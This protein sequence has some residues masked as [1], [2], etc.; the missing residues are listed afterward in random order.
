M[1]G[2][3]IHII[4]L[5]AF[6]PKGFAQQAPR[7]QI[8]LEDDWFSIAD[9]S[10]N[11]IYDKASVQPGKEAAGWQVVSIPH[12]WDTYHGVRRM[13]H[14]NRHGYAWY[15]HDFRVPKTAKPSRFF[16]FF[17][18]VGSYAAVFL[19]GRKVGEHA[20]GRTSFTLDI[21]DWVTPGATHLLTVKVGHPAGIRDLPWVCGGCSNEIGFSEGSQPMGIYRPVSLIITSPL[22]IEPFG[23]HAWNDTNV[24]EHR[25]LLHLSTEARNYG[26]QK[27]D[28]EI[29]HIVLD[30]QKRKL[31]EASRSSSLEPG[32]VNEIQT[33]IQLKGK[34][35]LWSPENPYLYSIVSNLYAQGKLVDTDT[36]PYGIRWVKWPGP[37]DSPAVFRLNG[38]PVFINGTAEYEHILG[39]SHAFSAT[40]VAA[41]VSQV[42]AAGYN[43]FRDAH[44]PHNLRYQHNWDSLG[45][46]WWPQMAAHIWFDNEAFKVNFKR[47]LIQWV[48]ERRNSPSNILWGL[49]NE[50]TLPEA[51][52]RECSD[53]IRKLDPTASVQ[54]KITTCNGGTGTDWDVPQNWTGT[55]GGDPATYDKDIQR[56]VLIGEYGAWRTADL[57]SEE[58]HYTSKL[59]S[60]ERMTRMMETKVRL[61]EQVKPNTAGHFHWLLYSHENPGRAQSG[62]GVREMDRIGPVNYKGLFTLWGEPTDVFYMYRSNYVSAQEEPMV[63]ISS[64]TWP[65]RWTTTGIKD[66]LVVYSNCDSVELFNGFAHSLGVKKR[67]GTG[68]HFRW[69]GVDIP[70]NKLT[71]VGY[72]KGKAVV[73][74]SIWLHH[75]P[76]EILQ[77]GQLAGK[78]D[79]VQPEAGKHYLYRLNCGGPAFTDK[80]GH[81]WLPDLP[82]DAANGFG[83]FSWTGQFNGL[84]PAFASQ[85]Y[86]Y[87][88]LSGTLQH[89]LFRYYRFGQTDLSYRFD[90]P[91]GDYEV[92]LFF[93][94][95]WYGVGGSLDAKGW[96]VFDV[97]IN[98]ETRIKDLDIFKEAGTHRALVK[99]I[100]V[101]VKN[102]KI[103]VSFPKVL[104]GQAVIAAIAITAR[105]A[106]GKNSLPAQAAFR[107]LIANA[108]LTEGD[109]KRT[110]EVKYWLQTGQP[111]MGGKPGGFA[112][113]PPMLFGAEWVKPVAAADMTENMRFSMDLQKESE[114]WVGIPSA[115]SAHRPVP[116][117]EGFSDTRLQVKVA[118]FE[119]HWWLYKKSMK[120]GSQLEISP[121]LRGIPLFIAATPV[122]SIDPAYDLK[123]TV[124][125][126]YDKVNAFSRGIQKDSING[127]AC[128]CMTHEKADTLVWPFT[129][130]VADMYALRFRYVNR[131]QEN[132]ELEMLIKAADGTVMKQETVIFEP[133]LANKWGL[134]ETNTGTTI[135]AG[136][137]TITLISKRAKGLCLSTLEVQ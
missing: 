124:S 73:K 137:Y 74:D 36:V 96:R 112:A 105:Q 87:R 44:Q 108:R 69:D 45:I 65:G 88:T 46:L 50:S 119:G 11:S 22:R 134:M 107:S 2:R 94:E 15:R 110:V 9:D 14:G 67:G 92:C 135:N 7:I 123:P 75:L 116:G 32:S 68:T 64:H 26:G 27:S 98:G 85:R 76:E 37:N 133:Y 83:S 77:Q 101:S 3:L 66:N 6:S 35:Q 121:M 47:L 125:F 39:N 57:H 19:N 129:V 10:L 80:W 136:N 72:V 131:T 127:R 34:V 104:S 5:L 53:L 4:F 52:A 28:F 40:Q 120:P 63:Y 1:K 117:M 99:K 33:D 18:G 49:E 128:V 84:H 30:R 130:G 115:D 25:A 132:Y 78:T 29:R 23:V 82:Y 95:P 13:K 113:L 60:E 91:D 106:N 12:N 56:Q 71:A 103:I 114:V 51:F 48:K 62:E 109:A 58:E 20:G 41:R 59:L 126:R 111:F 86:Q 97:A 42:R 89:D 54:R 79:V 43:A 55:Y 38:N 21:T 100:P 90:L 17:E 61:A 102:G 8:P 31:A 122:T 24:N 93:D 16:L 81:Q 70:F 118:G